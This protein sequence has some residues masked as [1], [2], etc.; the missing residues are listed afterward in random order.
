M[1]FTYSAVDAPDTSA[2]MA[3]LQDRAGSL[4]KA[5][6]A[7]FADAQQQSQLEAMQSEAQRPAAQGNQSSVAGSVAA[8]GRTPPANVSG[9]AAKNRELYNARLR[10]LGVPE[11][12]IAG[13]EWNVQDESGWK[14]S[15]VGDNGAAFGYNQ[16]NGPRKDELFAF[17]KE[18][19]ADPADPRL[20]ADNWH[21]EMTGAYK[22]TYD[23]AVAAGNANG[24]AVAILNGFERP[25][26]VHRTRREADYSG[27][28]WQPSGPVQA[29]P[30]ARPQMMSQPVQLDMGSYSPISMYGN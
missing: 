11:H 4:S 12:V 9:D 24:A 18:R 8:Y 25:A 2:L 19:G 30:Q 7:R 23:R 29:Q 13:N 1:A 22:S 28:V 10:E 21:R 27:R 14:S 5:A 26:E 20:Q 6:W 15:A 16:W 3:Q 17:A